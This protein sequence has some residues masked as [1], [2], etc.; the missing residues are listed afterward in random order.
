MPGRRRIRVV[1]DDVVHLE[2][3]GNADQPARADVQRRRLVV[4]EQV[5]GVFHAVFR[6]QVEGPR[7]AGEGRGQPA[8]HILPGAI[9][10][11]ADAVLDQRALLRLV[12]AVG[13]AGVVDPVAEE[14][15]A[16]LAA[17][18]DDLWMVVAHRD[19]ERDGAAHAGRVHRVHHAPPASAIAVVALRVGEH[20]GRRPGPGGALRVGRRAQLVEL[21]IGRDPERH[22]RAAGP[23]DPGPAAIG[24]V[25]VEAEIRPLN[26]W[27]AA[28]CNSSRSPRTPAGRRRI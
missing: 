6:Q 20:I 3:V 25:V 2:R 11:G 4:V 13:V 14:L 8:G 12:H 26:H 18:F 10:D 1:H 23:G 17:G 21:D 27:R 16:A 9:L 24:Q 7:R 15:P 22:P 28:S 19:V 5:A